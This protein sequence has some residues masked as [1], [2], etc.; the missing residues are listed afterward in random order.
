MDTQTRSA[1]TY[2]HT[3]TGYL[4]MIGLGLALFLNTANF[5]DE[6]RRRSRRA[7]LCLPAVAVNSTLAYLFSALT[8]EVTPESLSVGFRRGCLRRRVA[9][10]DVV[11]VE[12]VVVP[13]YHGWGIRLTRKGWLYKVQGRHAVRLELASGRGISIG[14]DE[15]EELA[16]A[17]EAAR[18]PVAAAA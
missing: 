8:V 15:P 11:G 14:T 18:Q 12:Q 3:Q 17:I 4:V 7:W 16:A 9:L 1:A 2:R 10:A 13:W 6:L 5:I